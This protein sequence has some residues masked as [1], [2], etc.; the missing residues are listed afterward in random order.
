[1][2]ALVRVFPLQD[3]APFFAGFISTLG[4]YLQPC[5]DEL[6]ARGFPG[7]GVGGFLA[8]EET[9]PPLGA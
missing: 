8:G 1:M 3:I 4:G 9:I 2:L 5:R 6:A 7:C